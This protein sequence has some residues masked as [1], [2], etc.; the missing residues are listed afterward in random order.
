MRSA[1]RR[2]EPSEILLEKSRKENIK[3]QNYMFPAMELIFLCVH[4]HYLQ[5][6]FSSIDQKILLIP[7]CVVNQQDILFQI[8]DLKLFLDSFQRSGRILHFSWCQAGSGKCYI[9]CKWKL[10]IIITWLTYLVVKMLG[11]TL[12]SIE[13]RFVAITFT[14][15]GIFSA[16]DATGVPIALI[17]EGKNGE[18]YIPL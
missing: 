9:F 14:Q 1:G 7:I 15:V 16:L 6:S 2:A 3:T 10:K 5:W 13:W 4:V 11:T 8:W 18:G 17:K 12:F